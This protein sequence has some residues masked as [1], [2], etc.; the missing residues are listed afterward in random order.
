MI[1][2]GIKK[3]CEKIAEGNDGRIRPNKIHVRNDLFQQVLGEM[4]NGYKHRWD[5]SYI[6]NTMEKRGYK[7]E[8]NAFEWSCYVDSYTE[9]EYYI[10][11]GG[12]LDEDSTNAYKLSEIRCNKCDN[13]PFVDSSGNYYC[14]ICV[15]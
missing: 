6:N 4:E 13:K 1:I 9:K 14:P 3:D 2:Q 5:M 10:E 12:R 15:Q 8:W 11:D 7:I